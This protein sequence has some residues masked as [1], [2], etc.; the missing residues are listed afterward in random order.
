MDT[1]RLK[2]LVLDDY[3]GELGHAPA[4]ER[5]RQL[6]QVTVLDRPLGLDDYDRLKE[7]QFVLALRERTKLDQRFFDACQNLE[8][9]LQTGGHAYHIDLN[10]ATQ[11]GI[12]IA[13][14]RHT[15]KPTVVVPE[16]ALG[17]M[18]GLVR[19]I[20]PLTMEMAQGK[21]SPVM[22]GSLFGRT[23]GILGYGRH[24][25]PV[26]KL[27]QAFGMNVIVW[28]R[29]GAYPKDEPSVRRVALD[30]LLKESDIVSIH[31]RL[32]DESRGLLNR[33]RIAQMKPGAILINTS[34]G[35]IVDES[36]LIDALREKRLA[37]AGLDVFSTEP[38]PVSSPLRTLPNV[39]LTPHIG[40]QVKDVFEEF[41][42]VAANQ[43]DAWLSQQLALAEVVNPE[44]IAVRRERHGGFK[45]I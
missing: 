13:L 4:M 39:L 32:S 10:L 38:L 19:H 30:Q 41:V 40:W 9:V 12:V 5:L 22:G 31:L 26:A 21:W 33:E 45:S 23:L 15:M 1:R 37:G 27:A 3:E 14:G 2:L 44:A 42:A 35:A 8:L 29:T 11:R 20:Y 28:N 7:F 36:A 25:Q 17:F 34:R 18:L 16:L 24:G 6:T 43:L